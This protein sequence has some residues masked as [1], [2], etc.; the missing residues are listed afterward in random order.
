LRSLAGFNPYIRG[1]GWDEIDLYSRFF[2]AGYNVARLPDHEVLCLDHG[3][4]ERVEHV[5]NARISAS[6]VKKAMNQK[7]MDVAIQALL[8]KLCWPG[9]DDY[10]RSYEAQ[11]TLPTLQPVDL[12]RDAMLRRLLRR[13]V[14]TLYRPGAVRQKAWTFLARLGLGPYAPERAICL[15]RRFGID[16]SLVV[17]AP[18][19][20]GRWRGTSRQG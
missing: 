6:L 18:M 20:H 12:I 4:A 9:F 1:W 14:A 15:L 11:R 5:Q 7:N 19:A 8:Q 3:D 16:L 2:L 17:Q 10:V 13:C